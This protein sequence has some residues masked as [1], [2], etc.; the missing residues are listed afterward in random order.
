MVSVLRVQSLL[1]CHMFATLDPLLLQFYNMHIKK[2]L[3][4]REKLMTTTLLIFWT[5]VPEGWYVCLVLVSS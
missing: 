1:L 3:M 4:M 2:V 5:Y